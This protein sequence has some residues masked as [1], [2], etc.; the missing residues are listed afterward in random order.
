MTAPLRGWDD[1]IGVVFIISLD[2]AQGWANCKAFGLMRNRDQAHI[3]AGRG[4]LR[5]SVVIFTIVFIE[6]FHQ[7]GYSGT[8]CI[9]VCIN[10]ASRSGNYFAVQVRREGVEQ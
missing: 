1:W 8:T 6:V 3:T 4:S 10:Y 9:C 5:T 7:Q 2:V